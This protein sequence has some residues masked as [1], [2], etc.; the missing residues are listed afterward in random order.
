LTASNPVVNNPANVLNCDWKSADNPLCGF[1]PKDANSWTIIENDGTKYLT[2]WLTDGNEV[3][4]FSEFFS[5]DKDTCVSFKYKIMDKDIK[6]RVQ[7]HIPNQGTGNTDNLDL[8][9][10][11]EGTAIDTTKFYEVKEQIKEKN[12]LM[13]LMFI[14]S[15]SKKAGDLLISGIEVTDGACP[16]PVVVEKLPEAPKPVE[17]KKEETKVITEVDAK[18]KS[19][20]EAKKE[21]IEK[22]AEH[23]K[24]VEVKEKVEKAHEAISQLHKD[25]DD[26]ARKA[27]VDKYKAELVA[28]QKK[29]QEL[30]AELDQVKVARDALEA[31]D[32]A[33]K[34]GLGGWSIFFIVLFT[35]ATAL[36]L[37]F[38]S[39]RYYMTPRY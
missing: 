1:T 8:F 4:I 6:L 15:G 34:S 14:A 7:E 16:V 20:E 2:V 36:G 33:K 13:Y 29:E 17:T 21:V 9:K 23:K 5:V 27:E 39:Y 32:K 18:V 19:V 24:A 22:E 37:A 12:K 10:P 26:P 11:V 31:K 38:V 35:L 25:S 28:A 3:R 30:K